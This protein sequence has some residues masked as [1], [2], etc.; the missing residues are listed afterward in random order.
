MTRSFYVTF[1][2]EQRHL[3]AS[4]SVPTPAADSTGW[5]EVRA[6]GILEA[7]AIVESH[8]GDQYHE[9]FTARG[10]TEY[11]NAHGVLSSG[12]FDVLTSHYDGAPDESY[13]G[14]RADLAAEAKH[15]A[16]MRGGKFTLIEP[17]DAAVFVTHEPKNGFS[18][19]V[20]LT[21]LPGD[22]SRKSLGSNAVLTVLQPF[23]SAKA[24]TV[25]AG[26]K[27]H[28]SYIAE[29]LVPKFSGH[30]LPGLTAAVNQ[31]IN[32]SNL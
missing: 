7:T 13:P 24:V 30:H 26:Q 11:V 2:P 32:L 17:S 22:S 4:G 29:H 18:Y 28:E 1:K 9:V 25:F 16:E 19:Q 8:Y 6:G 27:L 12:C 31:A 14:Q 5:V 15:D 23:Q 20:L 21:V 3:G 10:L